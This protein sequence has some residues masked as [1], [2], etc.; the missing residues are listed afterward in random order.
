M[1]LYYIIHNYIIYIIYYIILFYYINYYIYII[2]IYCILYYQ[3]NNIYYIIL[4]YIVLY[5]IILYYIILYYEQ[6]PWPQ[7]VLTFFR[8]LCFRSDIS[9][10]HSSF[11]IRQFVI[12]SCSCQG[13]L[14]G[15]SLTGRHGVS[16][17]RSRYV[18]VVHPTDLLFAHLRPAPACQIK[19]V[20]SC[21]QAYVPGFVP[22]SL[23]PF[24][25]LV[26]SSGHCWSVYISALRG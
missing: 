5:Y 18:L 2:F 15:V 23:G 8:S 3:I 13:V 1:R 24:R 19:H 9:N 10:P 22:L 25:S 12:C 11:C 14:P 20:V 26:A 4:Y 7:F 6:E 17:G 21:Q 16:L